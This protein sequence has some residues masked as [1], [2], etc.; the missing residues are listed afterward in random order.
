MLNENFINNLKMFTYISLPIRLGK[1]PAS[2]LRVHLLS[3]TESLVVS[4]MRS[5]GKCFKS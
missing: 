2:V 3:F 4:G 5:Q 1:L